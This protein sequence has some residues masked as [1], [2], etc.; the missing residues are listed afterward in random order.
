M[1]HDETA[2]AAFKRCSIG[3]NMK[4]L[5]E[6]WE[7]MGDVPEEELPHVLTKL[8]TFYE[9]RINRNPDDQEAVQFFINLDNA[10]SQTL[11]CNLNRR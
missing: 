3:D 9:E 2:A 4:K 6:I 8:F 11:D 7:E 5:M 10:I 1:Q